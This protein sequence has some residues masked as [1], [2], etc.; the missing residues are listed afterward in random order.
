MSPE[1]NTHTRVFS[2]L[3]KK[4][5]NAGESQAMITLKQEYCDAKRCLECA[6]GNQLLREKSLE[7][8]NDR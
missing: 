2:S 4:P 7:I 1:N 8:T 5:A 3:G 6:A